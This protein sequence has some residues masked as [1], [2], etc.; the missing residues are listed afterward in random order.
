ML[1]RVAERL[2]WMA[3]YLERLEDTSRLANA[4]SHLIL[5]LPR[6]VEPGW[7]V[8]ID[9]LNARERFR[10]RYTRE[11]ERNVIKFLL[12]DRD[13]PSSLRASARA[14]RENMRTTRDVL[15]APAWEL[16]NELYLFIEDQA[17]ASVPR[18]GRARFLLDVIGR[19]QQLNGLIESTVL[20]DQ[21]LY[22]MRLGR[23]LERADMT[24]RIVDVGATAILK[25]TSVPEVPLLW[26]NLLMSLSATSAYRRKVGPTLMPNPI[27]DF[28]FTSEQ[29]PR[30]VLY[31]V[32]ELEEMVGTLKAPRGLLVKLREVV[33]QLRGMD[34]EPMSLTDLHAF[35]DELQQ[36]LAFVDE[37]FHEQ[38]FDPGG[39]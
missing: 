39:R 20:R 38:W 30:S 17:D 5:D 2:Y 19:A 18:A 3:R 13:N 16:V 22:F 26:A 21:P 23:L 6:G 14:A 31:C 28:L 8:L 12:A 9:T 36:R 33:T 11:T 27:V 32:N 4:Y 24:S 15:P 1:S 10:R 29:F 35:I 7:S 34:A 25:L 37:S